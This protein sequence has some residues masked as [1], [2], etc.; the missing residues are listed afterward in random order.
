MSKYCGCIGCRE[1]ADT[2]IS[3]PSRPGTMPVCESH[4]DGHQEAL[5]DE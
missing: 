2:V 4:A 5:G 1:T 3:R